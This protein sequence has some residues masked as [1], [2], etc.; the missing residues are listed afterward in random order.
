MRFYNLPAQC[1]S[2]TCA[3]C[4]CGEE[5]QQGIPQHMGHQPAAPIRYFDDELAA[6]VADS[7]GDVV[8]F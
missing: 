3:G 4:F 8:W 1:Q 6:V 5:R 2:K 7:H